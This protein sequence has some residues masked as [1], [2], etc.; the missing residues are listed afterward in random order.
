M[1]DLC[2]LS[3]KFWKKVR[4]TLAAPSRWRSQLTLLTAISQTIDDHG[5]EKHKWRPHM[6]RGLCDEPLKK[7]DVLNSIT[8]KHGAI[9]RLPRQGYTSQLSVHA[10]NLSYSTCIQWMGIPACLSG[11]HQILKGIYPKIQ[12]RPEPMTSASWMDRHSAGALYSPAGSLQNV[13]IY[14]ELAGMVYDYPPRISPLQYCEKAIE[15]ASEWSSE[16]WASMN[17]EKGQLRMPA[18]AIRQTT[19]YGNVVKGPG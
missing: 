15:R 13:P 6:I 11:I 14:N 16:A 12:N 9:E 8:R 2:T 19:V 3:F 18:V 17:T 10:R 4:Q 7:I 1:H 5:P